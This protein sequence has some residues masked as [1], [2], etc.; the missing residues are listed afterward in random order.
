M[1]KEE[2][3]GVFTEQSKPVCQ[4]S[5]TSDTLTPA[6][7]TIKSGH[8][9]NFTT[10]SQGNTSS[11]VILKH[12]QQSS[13]HSIPQTQK[14]AENLRKKTLYIN[15]IWFN[16]FFQQ[17][18]ESPPGGSPFQNDITDISFITFIDKYSAWSSKETE[19]KL[20]HRMMQQINFFSEWKWTCI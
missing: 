7:H 19:F 17:P 18:A 16:F 4:T 8:G 11:R 20:Y 10:S 12:Q 5:T 6:T 15:L 14:Q 1:R 2:S 9:D 3:E 13:T